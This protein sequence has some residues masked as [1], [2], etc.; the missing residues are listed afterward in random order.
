MSQ[1]QTKTYSINDFVEWKQGGVL[2]LSPKFQRRSVWTQKAKSYFLDSVL[3]GKPCP[4]VLIREHLNAPQR[5][6]IRE[7]VDGQQRLRAVF[8]YIEDGFPVSRTHNKEHGGKYFSDLAKDTQTAV[9]AY[10]VA[11]DCLINISDSEVRDIFARLNTYGVKLNTIELLHAEYYGAFRTSAFELANEFES[12]WL[13]NDVLSEAS[14]SRMKDAELSAELLVSFVE[15]IQDKGRLAGYFKLWDDSFPNRTTHERQF[16]ATM[17]TIGE[18]FPDGLAA[19]ELHRPVLFYSLFTAVAHMQ[20]GLPGLNAK[21][22]RIAPTQSARV[23]NNLSEVDVIWESGGRNEQESE[24]LM[25]AR[26]ATTHQPERERRTKFICSL[27][28]KGL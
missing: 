17:D 11:T 24:F 13:R 14:L 25:A 10:Q 15:G 12:F 7:V 2:E 19:H 4:K 20:F 1:F 9:L 26:R 27:I 21:R 23:F 16:R 6:T 22:T 3:R 18:L 8:E 5:K 28:R